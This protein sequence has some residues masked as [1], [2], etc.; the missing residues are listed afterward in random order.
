MIKTIHQKLNIPIYMIYPG[1]HFVTGDRCMIK[2]VV[3]SCVAVCLHDARLKMGGM[4]NFIVPGMIGT[5]GIMK[6]EIAEHGIVNLEYMMAEIVKRGGDRR[7]LTAKIFGAGY[8][9]GIGDGIIRSNINFLH[10]Y[11][12]YEHIPVLKEDLGGNTRRELVINPISGGVFRKLLRNNEKQ[13]EFIRLERE[14]IDKAF[15]GKEI[16]THYVLFE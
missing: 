1:E 9:Q 16:I 14:Y 7:Q 5:E 13:S 4:G 3:G 12:S 6:N 2:T 11:F 15:K 10:E 8:H